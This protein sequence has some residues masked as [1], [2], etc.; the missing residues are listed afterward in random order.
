MPEVNWLIHRL[1]AVSSVFFVISNGALLIA[2][3][4]DTDDNS[5]L[6]IISDVAVAA[7]ILISCVLVFSVH[8][9]GLIIGMLVLAFI[10]LGQ[11]HFQI[12]CLVNSPALRPCCL[13]Y[14]CT[15]SNRSVFHRVCHV[16]THFCRRQFAH[17]RGG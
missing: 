4:S 3:L 13:F 15:R 9:H 2:S 17:R 16:Q 10:L 14:H 6:T 7:L 1:V 8:G 11:I 5:A 12:I